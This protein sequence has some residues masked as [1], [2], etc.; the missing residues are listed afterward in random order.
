MV[1]RCQNILKSIIGEKHA[2]VVGAPKFC[3]PAHGT[4]RKKSTIM[5]FTQKI[6]KYR[7]VVRACKK[8]PFFLLFLDF[9]EVRGETADLDGK[10]VSP[11]RG[12]CHGVLALSMFYLLRKKSGPRL[13]YLYLRS[14]QYWENCEFFRKH[15]PCLR[16]SG[17]NRPL[18]T[19]RSHFLL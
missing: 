1:N 7:P 4:T 8:T 16:R 18:S 10:E 17:L 6:V 13:I 9:R 11:L 2:F 19:A 15:R 5:K 3:G 14:L 12:A